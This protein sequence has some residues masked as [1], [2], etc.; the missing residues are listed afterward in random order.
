MQFEDLTLGDALKLVWAHWSQ[1]LEPADRR[2]MWAILHAHTEEDM[3]RIQEQGEEGAFT[4]DKIAQ[5]RA[6]REEMMKR[7][8]PAQG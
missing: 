6:L 5:V 4:T 7:S 1:G 8:Q 3:K 2:K